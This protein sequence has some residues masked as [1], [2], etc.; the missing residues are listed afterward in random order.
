MAL[1]R[2]TKPAS[3]RCYDTEGQLKYYLSRIVMLRTGYTLSTSRTIHDNAV[4]VSLC[5]LPK[6]LVL[7]SV[8]SL[9]LDAVRFNQITH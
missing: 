2:A 1:A 8:I 5:E 9:H 3:L 4:T 6:S 7:V